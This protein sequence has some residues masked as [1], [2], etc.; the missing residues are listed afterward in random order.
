[1]NFNALLSFE[2]NISD[3]DLLE[4]NQ[5]IDL[6]LKQPVEFFSKMRHLQPQIGCLNCCN[7]HFYLQNYLLDLCFK[8]MLYIISYFC[9]YFKQYIAN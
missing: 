7:C 1:M 3:D 2:Q 6:F 8:F 5:L 4:R 9:L